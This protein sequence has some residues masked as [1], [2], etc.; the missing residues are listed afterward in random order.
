MRG[1]IPTLPTR[2]HGVVHGS[3]QGQLPLCVA[4]E[5]LILPLRNRELLSLDPQT[6][7]TVPPDECYD[8]TLTYATS[9]SFQIHQS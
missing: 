7:S 1:A 3:V 4:V 8:T 2:L 6:L 9:A 5:G